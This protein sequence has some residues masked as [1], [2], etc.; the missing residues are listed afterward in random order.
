MLFFFILL[1]STGGIFFYYFFFEK[2][3]KGW[4]A[5]SLFPPQPPSPLLPAITV[6]VAVRNEE[7][8]IP[9]LLHYLLMQ[10][11][12]REKLEIII[13][14]DG[15]SDNTA[16]IVQTYL[17]KDLPLTLIEQ[18]HGGKKQAIVH[19][20]RN[21]SHELIVT[22]DAD[23]KMGKEWLL[24]IGNF[25]ASHC[26]DMVIAPVEMSPSDKFTGQFQMLD[27]YAMIITGAGMA[28]TGR[29]VLCNGANLAFRK[30]TFLSFEDP[31]L[32][33]TPSGDDVFLLLSFKKEKRKI[34]FLK[35]EEAKV[36]IPPEGSLRTFLRQRIRWASKTKFYRDKDIL[37][38]TALVWTVN[39]LIVLN[40]LMMFASVRYGII[41]IMMIVI[42][43]LADY[44]LLNAYCRFCKQSSA[45]RA[46]FPAQC[47]YPF[48]ITFMGIVSQF[49]PS[50][51]K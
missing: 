15:S 14:D 38:L 19:A 20:L 22:T 51:W 47:L 8:N 24:S 3:Y 2:I 18:P 11:Y 41:A 4:S 28:G 44:R 6:V 35:S 27:F 30:E 16:S 40:I 13:V 45:M 31:L 5:L 1:I 32:Q 39:F 10:N 36:T 37:M 23:C 46:F 21:A 34:C 29:P 42:K 9:S 25:Y 49:I 43:S 50:R 7:K 48:Y 26:P 12:P 33:K 17:N